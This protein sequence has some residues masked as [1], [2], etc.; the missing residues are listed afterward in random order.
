[1]II[2]VDERTPHSRVTPE[3]RES[4]GDLSFG[5]LRDICSLLEKCVETCSLLRIPLP[6]DLEDLEDVWTV[7]QAQELGK[8]VREP[9]D[10]LREAFVGPSLVA[11]EHHLFGEV[12]IS[13]KDTSLNRVTDIEPIDHTP[14]VLL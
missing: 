1:M 7:L 14:E 12:L 6:G 2:A 11:G 9:G 5:L 13:G 10:A 4:H 8:V 3:C